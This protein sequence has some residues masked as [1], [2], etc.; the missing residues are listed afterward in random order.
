MWTLFPSGPFKQITEITGLHFQT[1]FSALLPWTP[2]SIYTWLILD[3]IVWDPQHKEDQLLLEKV[4]LFAAR[5]P[6]KSWSQDQTSLFTS[7][8][9]PSLMNHSSYIPQT[10]F[11]FKVLQPCF[12]F[13]CSSTYHPQH[14]LRQD[15]TLTVGI[16]M[17][18]VESWIKIWIKPYLR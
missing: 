17:V 13:L 16:P 1:I 10:Y 18:K 11:A 2:F 9:L 12:L 14:N 8:N 4:Q 15:S 3:R 6:I 7:L 5:L